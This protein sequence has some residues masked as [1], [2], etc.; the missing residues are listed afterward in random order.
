MM[1]YECIFLDRDGTLNPDSGY[2]N[3]VDNFIFYNFT[4]PALKQLS[5]KGFQFCIITNQSGLNR[6]IIDYSNFEIINNFIFEEFR[7]HSIKLLD[8]YFCPDHPNDAT[9]RRKPGP[10]MFLEAKEKYNL[11]LMKCLMIGDSL[12]DMTAAEFLGMDMML[13]LTGNGNKVF[14]DLKKYHRITYIVDNLKQGA[15]ILCH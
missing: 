9:I 15:D 1:R 11:N 10:G 6:G 4:I 7:K 12:I 13:V 3:N 14:N 2:I 5:D 8:I